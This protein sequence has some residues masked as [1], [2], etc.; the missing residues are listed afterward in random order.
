MSVQ[1]SNESMRKGVSKVEDDNFPTHPPSAYEAL[2]GSNPSPEDTQKTLKGLEVHGLSPELR[3]W[4]DDV[5][6][7]D[8]K[9]DP[10]NPQN[11][12]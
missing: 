4:P 7:F 12:R 1:S 6:S 8:S 5:V 11:V 10:Q 3:Q 9:D 2:T